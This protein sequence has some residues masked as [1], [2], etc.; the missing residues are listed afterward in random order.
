MTTELLGQAQVIEAV[1]FAQAD[2]FRTESVNAQ[3]IRESAYRNGW[4]AT[5]HSTRWLEGLVLLVNQDILSLPESTL[6]RE[7]GIALRTMQA[8]T[9]AECEEIAQRAG[10]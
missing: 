6:D 1:T 3:R 5:P 7:V 8:I 4:A 2:G 10:L 9:E